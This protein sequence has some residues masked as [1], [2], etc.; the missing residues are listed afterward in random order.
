MGKKTVIEQ[1]IR[2]HTKELEDSI[3]YITPKLIE[4]FVNIYGKKHREYITNVINNIDYIFFISEE[5]N[6]EAL[7]YKGNSKHSK[8]IMANYLKYL[9]QVIAK[10]NTVSLNDEDKYIIK[11]VIP[12]FPFIL[13]DYSFFAKAIADDTA[14]CMVGPNYVNGNINYKYVI[15]LPIFTID[16]KVIIHEIN[17]A[18]G[19]SPLLM[20][21]NM[22]L[23]DFLFRD[24]VTEEL[25]NDYISE[26]VLQEYIRI[27]GI[28]PKPLRRVK[29]GN[30]YKAK[31]YIVKYLFDILDYIILESRISGNY[32]LFY[33]FVGREN[34]NHLCDLII[35]L[36]TKNYYDIDEHIELINVVN[37]MLSNIENA[38]VKTSEERL[39][40]LE[41]LGYT[42]R[43]L[44]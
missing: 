41:N 8:K 37:S 19:T 21:D 16:L 29:I 44:K 42:L 13:E 30:A 20:M 17:H 2:K 7:N 31:D 4:A 22:L 5:F 40:E 3:S 27:G 43:R 34:V 35:N 9:N 28:I 39:K 15:L 38:Q 36:Y 23:I 11:N 24:E 33:E 1:N 14:C 25:T 12:R 32:N 6:E 26:L 18:L 10:F